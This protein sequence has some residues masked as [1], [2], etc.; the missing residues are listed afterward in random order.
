MIPLIIGV[1]ELKFIKGNI[2]A[3]IDKVLKSKE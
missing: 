1:G 3:E 2:K